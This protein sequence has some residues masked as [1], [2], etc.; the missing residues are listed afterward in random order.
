[1]ADSH[2]SGHGFLRTQH[3]LI[4]SPSPLRKLT[5]VAVTTALWLLA[6]SWI[7]IG[8]VAGALHFV[9][10]PRIGEM[11][12]WLE[13]QATRTLGV[14]VRIG[15]I[16]ARSNG[17]IPSIEIK[18]VSLLDASGRL[19][20]QVPSV[21]AA[22]SARSALGLGFEQ[23]FVEGLVLEVRRS[24]DGRIWVAGFALPQE[25]S[26]DS[27][28]ADWLFEQ[29]EVAVRHG[30]VQ[31]TDETRNEPSLTLSDVD[32]VLR[33][34]HR[35]HS[36]RLDAS[37]PSE[38][39]AR[40]TVQGKLVEPLL[41]RDNEPWRTWDGQLHASFTAVDLAYLKR[42]ANLGVDLAQG[43]GALRAWVD[44]R[45][46]VAVGVSADVALRDVEVRTA[47]ALEP[48]ALATVTGRL[49]VKQLD[50]GAEYETQA[51]QFDTR[52]GL[53]WPGGNLQVR[54]FAGDMLVPARGEVVG[55]QLDLAAMAQIAGRLPLG[56][57]ARN[58]LRD[59][60]P[61]GLVRKVQGQWQGSLSQ[62]LRYTAK[63]RLEKLSIAALASPSASTPGFAGATVDFDVNQ[64]GGRAVFAIQGG[65]L[66]LPGV[67]EDPR[68]PMELFN[69]DVQWKVD[70]TQISVS[71][72]NAHFSN[73]D[74]QGDLQLKWHTAEP[75]E[76]AARG[77]AGDMRFPGVLD[78]QGSLVRAAASRVHRYLP[79][80]LEKDVRAYV[81]D[82]VLRGTATNVKFRLKGALRDFPY[83]EPAQ[84]DF[85][86]SANVE[87]L[88]F[89]YVPASL[90]RKDSAQWPTL[91]IA[92]GDFLLDRALLQ[93]NVKR[94][95][96]AGYP[97]L[98]LSKAEGVVRDLYHAATIGVT[99]EA[100]GPLGELLGFINTSPL[101]GILGGALSGATGS[102]P[103]DYKFKLDFPLAAVERATVQ[104]SITLGSNELQITPQTPRMARAKGVIGFSE[105]GFTVTG[106]QVR[107]LGGDARI[108]GGMYFGSP[109]PAG[110]KAPPQVLRINGVA[111]ADGIRQAR[112]LGPPARLAQFATGSTPFTATIGVRASVPEVTVYS[113]LV[114][115]ALALP[116]PFVKA[117][118]NPM[119]LRLETTALRGAKGDQWQVDVGRLAT[120]TYVRDLSG[121]EPKVLR[122]AMALGLAADESAPMPVDGVNANISLQ[123]LDLDA[124]SE[125]LNSSV[126]DVVAAPP[127]ASTAVGMAYLPTSM[128]VRAGT[129]VFGGRKL[130]NVVLGGTREG[131]L[132]R[133]NLDA[134]EMSGYVEYRQSA[135]AAAGRVYA[136]LAR[137]AFGQGTAQ[138]VENL[139]D[140]QPASIPALD[141]VVED[142]ELRGKK[143]G[144]V[145]VDAVNLTAGAGRDSRREWRLNRFN[146][147]TPEAVLTAEG[148]W[149]AIVRL[150]PATGGSVQERRRT[151]MNFKLDITDAGELLRRFGMTGVVRKGRGKIEGR[152]G[153]LGSPIALDYPSMEG[154][155]NVN[156]AN[157]QFL[158]ADPGIAKLLGVLSL[159]SLPRRLAFD[160]ND[161]FSEGFAFDYFRGDVAI[162]QGIART[163]NLQ[164]KGVAATVLM[165]GQTDIHKETQGVKVV[166]VPEINAGSAS[167]IASIVNPIMGLSTFLAQLVLRL[168]LMEAA[169]Q[170]FFIDGTWVE[171]RVTRVERK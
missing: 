169:T 63:G 74:A 157:G 117:A 69:S 107:A 24:A 13:Q 129:V 31:W 139:L 94:A 144:R 97:G 102:G 75:P 21:L 152:V 166:V 15:S 82:A 170:E 71:L 98:Q 86:V 22:V 109:P 150:S 132:W 34:R 43:S 9:I 167:V 78:L 62:P 147:M 79:L 149:T 55:D 77:G 121:P 103:A 73:A 27:A 2:N 160:F 68:I 80:S 10:V 51:L 93:V 33:N 126:G 142:F 134:S 124:W 88:A 26:T 16:E 110:A 156:V 12:P 112:E 115:L 130:N 11:R 106:A 128:A 146:I 119:P 56:D 92:S 113:S 41:S 108:E 58:A 123:N 122:G 29:T 168:P 105:L 158:K 84:G 17:L 60:A 61:Q 136:R 155:L 50:G 44:V 165:E 95:G 135:G 19:A 47:P 140:E 8:L 91:Q 32:L 6:I 133:A 159:Q 100:R 39:G 53:H 59:Y 89:A 40:F 37:P 76:G 141:I 161:V 114:G 28:R 163:S 14:T 138:D 104:G 25:Q 72:P 52:D 4:D 148:N 111:S 57:D 137:L 143:L 162:A 99:A 153:W 85:R 7:A 90:L 151:A 171:P 87:D 46:G 48:L 35:S 83:S 81:R 42:Y 164:M 64:S 1:M 36:L 131:L 5:A 49:S 127:S 30:T 154:N 23:L 65:A 45:N 54:L 101:G 116:A 38:W 20:L 18:N 70:G 96:V 118:D 120:V 125:V 66:E 67:F 3:D 145:E